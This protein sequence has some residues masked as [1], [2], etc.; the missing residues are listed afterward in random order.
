MNAVPVAPAPP[1]ADSSAGVSPRGGRAD[2]PR[3]DNGFAARLEAASQPRADPPPAN[4]QGA[5]VGATAEVSGEVQTAGEEQNATAADDQRDDGDDPA[6]TE[7][8]ALTLDEQI[9]QMLAAGGVPEPVQVAVTDAVTS[10]LP[11]GR[12][13]M[14]LPPDLRPHTPSASPAAPTTPSVALGAAGT[15]DDGSTSQAKAPAQPLTPDPAPGSAAPP[16]QDLSNPISPP[17]HALDATN[18]TSGH[19]TS[20]STA[21][22]APAAASPVA[23][24]PVA[25]AVVLPPPVS[26]PSTSPPLPAA[27]LPQ[28]DPAAANDLNVAR[29]ERA[30]RSAVQQQAGSL[31]LRMHPQS[32]GFV[33]IDLHVQ[34]AVVTASLRAESDAARHLL[35]ENLGS[36]RQALENQGLRVERLEVQSRPEP[37]S[38]GRQEHAGD[39]RSRGGLDQRGEGAPRRQPRQRQS[40]AQAAQAAADAE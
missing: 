22:A 38:A 33:R 1:I 21:P 20:P 35:T 4:R 14:E 28:G 32:M 30:L 24:A 26:D 3:E 31:T 9:E 5:Q 27:P 18:A 11:A 29:V 34:H 17:P 7:A 25:S 16:A 8:S 15:P 12:G 19:E 13:P 6:A 10:S 40:F 2:M 39:G 36:L 23:P 37:A